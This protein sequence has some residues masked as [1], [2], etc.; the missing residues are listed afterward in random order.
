MLILVG[1][2]P[3]ICIPFLIKAIRTASRSAYMLDLLRL[4]VGGRLDFSVN[5]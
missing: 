2:V 1:G 3:I 4:P 5:S